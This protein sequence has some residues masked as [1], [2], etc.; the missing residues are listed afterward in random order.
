MLPENKCRAASIESALVTENQ[1]LSKVL[2]I[3]ARD[4]SSDSATS[5]LGVIFQTYSYQP[6]QLK[7]RNTITSRI[8]KKNLNKSI[9][10]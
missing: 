3:V 8:Y 4:T 5:T 7:I 9:K 2:Q 1:C 10:T 6:I